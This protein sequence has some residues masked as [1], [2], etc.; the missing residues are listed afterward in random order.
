MQINANADKSFN[1][2]IILKFL[3]TF[4]ENSPLLK[5]GTIDTISGRDISRGFMMA[6][7]D[8]PCLVLIGIFSHRLR[9][10]SRGDPRFIVDLH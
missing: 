1:K 7:A 4:C 2:L 3:L 8:L 6:F 10:R 9:K 5:V